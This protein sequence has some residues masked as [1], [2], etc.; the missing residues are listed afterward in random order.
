[1]SGC[2]ERNCVLITRYIS[3]DRKQNGALD[4]EMPNVRAA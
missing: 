3:F 1:M 2:Y 4:A